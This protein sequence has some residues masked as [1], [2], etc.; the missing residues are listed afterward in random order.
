MFKNRRF[1][2]Q[3]VFGK[4]IDKFLKMFVDE[5]NI[6]IMTWEEHLEHFSFM[7]LK[8]REVN[9]KLNLGKCEFT[10]TCVGI[11]GHVVNREEHNQIKRKLRKYLNFQYLH[12]WL[13]SM[14]FFNLLVF[15]WIIGRGIPTYLC[16]SL[17]Y[18]RR[19]QHFHVI[20]LS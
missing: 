14:H 18:Q 19:I 6:Y 12:L 17:D 16:L 5:L 20:S 3:E 15:T 1:K 13:M 7:M 8:L 4:Y 9:L 2:I 11:L 10:K